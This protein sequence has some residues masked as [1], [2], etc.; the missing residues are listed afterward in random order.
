MTKST[1]L[2]L[3]ALLATT[4]I[5]SA[6]LPDSCGGSTLVR[7]HYENTAKIIALRQM[8]GDSALADS[9]YIPATLYNPILNAL[10][11]VYNATQFPERDTVT[12][13]LDI[14]SSPTPVYPFSIIVTSDTTNIWARKL[15]QG[16]YPSGDPT[17]DALLVNYQ[18]DLVDSS[19]FEQFS[20]TFETKELLNTLALAALFDSIPGTH[21]VPNSF[22]GGSNNIT[23]DTVA[24]GT[25]LTYTVKWGDCPAG[26]INNRSWT[27]LI[28]P[29]CS[30]TFLSVAGDPLTSEVVC[31]SNSDCT[32]NPL[33]LPWLQDSIQS[34][35]AQHPDCHELASGIHVTLHQD[36]NSVPV[37]GIHVFI[38]I[39][40][41]FTDFFYCNGDYIGT[42]QITIG[43]AGCMP[44]SVSNY[45]DFATDTIWDCTKPLPTPEN[46]GTT[47]TRTPNVAAISFQLSPNPATLGQTLVQANFGV[48]TKGRLSVFD[49]LGKSVLEK[50]FE[51]DQLAEM[52][53]LGSQKPGIYFVRLDTG[54]QVYT[55]KLLIIRP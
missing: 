35:A 49:V 12:T 6:Q 5:L 13:C 31:T 54:K 19:K 14:Q 41:A 34:Y 10:A 33:C 40:A 55:R 11:A 45:F 51:A 20:F 2:L 36:F 39:D 8:L 17:I 29:D 53:D 18:L 52:L 9:V 3:L 48:R 7:R 27:F 46:C 38:G 25:T 15:Y 30:V 50:T 4:T 44:E 42:C 16:A 21:A 43:G 22:I 47:P 24:E 37:I 28:K 26:C 32:I 1:T 23:L